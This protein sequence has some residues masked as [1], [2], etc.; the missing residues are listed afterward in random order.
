MCTC[1]PVCLYWCP[2]VHICTCPYRHGF[3]HVWAPVCTGVC[4]GTCTCMWACTVGSRTG[5]TEGLGVPLLGLRLWAGL[6]WGPR[7]HRPHPGQKLCSTH[8]QL[9]SW[10][11]WPSGC[12]PLVQHPWPSVQGLC[13]PRPA[14][15]GF[16]V[17]RVQRGGLEG[18][19]PPAGHHLKRLPAPL[20]PPAHAAMNCGSDAAS[21]R[22]WGCLRPRAAGASRKGTTVTRVTGQ[23]AGARHAVSPE[24]QNVR[25]EGQGLAGVQGTARAVTGSRLHKTR[26]GSGS[27]GTHH[28][29]QEVLGLQGQG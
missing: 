16:S 11:P 28:P 26:T 9:V 1:E 2:G 20:P 7:G 3:A 21:T 14:F 18:P 27:W 19:R 22:G 29:S 25:Q 4:V 12:P 13:L 8:L 24:S 17:L 6:G 15:W 23:A 5:S 10:P